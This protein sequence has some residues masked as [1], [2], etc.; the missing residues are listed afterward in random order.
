MFFPSWSGCL[1]FYQFHVVDLQRIVRVGFTWLLLRWVDPGLISLSFVL[2]DRISGFFLKELGLWFFM[3]S[4]VKGWMLKIV[5]IIYMS[6]MARFLPRGLW[7]NLQRNIMKWGFF[8]NKIWCLG[9]AM[10]L[11]SIF[12]CLLVYGWVSCNFDLELIY[13]CILVFVLVVLSPN[14][15]VNSVGL[16]FQRKICFLLAGSRGKF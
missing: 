2:V 14:N 13:V 15:L 11:S 16:C 8:P 3:P 5:S 7:S 9:A 10:L 6:C 4:A 12:L 1:F